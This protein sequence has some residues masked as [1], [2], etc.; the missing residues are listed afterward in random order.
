MKSLGKF[1]KI[2]VSDV[3]SNHPSLR[4]TCVGYYFLTWSLFWFFMIA[5][6]THMV[7]MQSL[8]IQKRCVI[9]SSKLLILLLEYF[10]WVGGWKYV[11]MQLPDYHD[12]IEHPMD[13]ATVRKKLANG[14]YPTLEQFEVCKCVYTAQHSS[15][16]SFACFTIF[17]LLFCFLLAC[18]TVFGCWR[19]FSFS[20]ERYHISLLFKT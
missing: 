14:S 1:A 8:L 20:A 18:C 6:R 12:V 11:W 19:F 2:V 13:F 5:G 15:G 16:S 9:L 4:D 3:S 10:L 17:F 7:C